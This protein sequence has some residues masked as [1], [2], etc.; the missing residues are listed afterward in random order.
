MNRPGDWNCMVS[1]GE[2]WPLD[3]RAEEVHITDIAHAL[4]RYRYSGNLS[5]QLRAQ[6][7]EKPLTSYCPNDAEWFAEH[8]RLF[9]TNHALLALLRPATHALFMERWKPVS[10]D[11]WQVELGPGVP[12]RIIQAALNKIPK[13]K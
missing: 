9:V 1:G 10:H 4:K 5:I 6:S 13:K 3:P 12:P 11:D 2:F 7:G 8:F